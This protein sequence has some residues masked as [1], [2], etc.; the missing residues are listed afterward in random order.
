MALG[1]CRCDQPEQVK[2]L[3]Q[4]AQLAG[5]RQD[6]AIVLD[7]PDPEKEFT[8]AA[9][10]PYPAVPGLRRDIQKWWCIPLS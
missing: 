3:R 1:C 9:A 10:R 5:I 4:Q 8:E 7:F 6:V 2:T